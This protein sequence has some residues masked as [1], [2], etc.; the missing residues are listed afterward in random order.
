MIKTLKEFRIFCYEIFDKKY[1]QFYISGKNKYGQI[2][3]FLGDENPFI[4]MDNKKNP[5]KLTLSWSNTIILFEFKDGKLYM[6]HEGFNNIEVNQIIKFTV[7]L[8]GFIEKI[9]SLM[10]KSKDFVPTVKLELKKNGQQDLEEVILKSKDIASSLVKIGL[11]TEYI[12]LFNFFMGDEVLSMGQSID[13]KLNVY[14]KFNNEG[15][16]LVA[17]DIKDIIMIQ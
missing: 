13:G 17:D 16:I 5:S 12:L 9:M 15:Q 1:K 10:N 11:C 7:Q 14:L 4:S 6:T 3:I 2:L 8:G